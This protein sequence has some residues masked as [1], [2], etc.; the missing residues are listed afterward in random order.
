MA[1][2]LLILLQP[3]TGSNLNIHRFIKHTPPSHLGD[4]MSAPKAFPVEVCR[5]SVKCA[6]CQTE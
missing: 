6:A 3:T 4:T 1:P 5:V 2:E